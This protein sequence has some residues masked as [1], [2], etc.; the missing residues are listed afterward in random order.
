MGSINEFE[1]ITINNETND[2]AAFQRQQLDRDYFRSN[3]NVMFLNQ[4]ITWKC[5]KI[6]MDIEKSYSFI[7]SKIYSHEGL[8]MI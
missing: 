4:I 8:K 5:L 7:S 2:I 1:L 3:S 6:V